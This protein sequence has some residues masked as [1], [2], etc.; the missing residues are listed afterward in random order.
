[1]TKAAL[2]AFT[3]SLAA[4]VGRRGITV[5]TIAPGAT[6]TEMNTDILNKEETRQYVTQATA[7]RRLGNVTDIAN[8]A[9]FLASPESEWIT[10][11]YIEASGGLR[12]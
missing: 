8:V 2:N 11:Q 10:G 4:D 5:N 7:L 6:E 1:M 9:A 12:L 3:T